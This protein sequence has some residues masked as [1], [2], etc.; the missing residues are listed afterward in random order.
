[1][2]REGSRK[3]PMVFDSQTCAKV[4]WLKIMITVPQT[5]VMEQAKTSSE[6]YKT[7]ETRADQHP[8][9]SCRN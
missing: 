6:L 8:A 1:M 7:P 3:D 9:I 5:V 4:T 2:G